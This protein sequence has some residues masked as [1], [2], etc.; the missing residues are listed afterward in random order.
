MERRTQRKSLD[1]YAIKESMEEG[2]ENKVISE[3]TNY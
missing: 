3:N 1:K 2:K